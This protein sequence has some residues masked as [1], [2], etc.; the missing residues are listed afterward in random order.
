LG[1]GGHVC[2][3]ACCGEGSDDVRGSGEVRGEE[4]EARKDGGG[5]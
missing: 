3:C 5:S 2:G 4:A 1:I